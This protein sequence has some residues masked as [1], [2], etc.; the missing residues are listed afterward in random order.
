MTLMPW[1]IDRPLVWNTTCMHILAASHISS[2]Y[3]SAEFA[4]QQMALKRNKYA[5]IRKRIFAVFKIE[6][7]GP[8]GLD[9]RSF[10]RSVALRLVDVSRDQ[11]LIS[12]LRNE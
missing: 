8:W 7:L 9:A 1:K 10:C 3:N 11:R 6:L 12:I 5:F 2:A 4:A